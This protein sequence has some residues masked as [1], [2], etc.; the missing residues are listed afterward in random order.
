[1]NGSSAVNR[2]PKLLRSDIL[3]ST[4]NPPLTDKQK[5]I[6][7]VRKNIKNMEQQIG[8]IPK[9]YADHL[10]QIVRELNEL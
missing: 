3:S 5:A 6:K 4:N 10:K 1:M 9:L 8:V 2:D 7:I